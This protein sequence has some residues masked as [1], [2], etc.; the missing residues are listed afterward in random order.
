MPQAHPE[1]VDH[2]H[3]ACGATC[4]QCGF[5]QAV[6][7]AVDQLLTQWEAARISPQCVSPAELAQ[8]FCK[9]LQRFPAL[10]GRRVRS[11]WV[12]QVYPLFCRSRAA[13]PPPA[14]KDFAQALA[15]VMPRG[16]G[17]EW[18]RGRRIS[19]TRYQVPAANVI[20]LGRTRDS[21]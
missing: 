3:A 6:N 21:G 18:K 8:A 10:V 13:D 19:F 20:P 4:P 11:S 12:R 7:L 1:T 5:D 17:E 15:M 16:R 2:E 14:F 9:D